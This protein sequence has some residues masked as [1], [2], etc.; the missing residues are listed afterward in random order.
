MSESNL[1]LYLNLF[2]L[3][4]Y[5]TALRNSILLIAVAAL[6]GGCS[7]YCAE[8]Q[9]QYVGATPQASE[10]KCG[11]EAEVD[12]WQLQHLAADSTAQCVSRK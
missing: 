4:L 12:T 10:K 7:E 9:L 11:N 1:Y 3:A 8:C 5:M 2:S 6:L